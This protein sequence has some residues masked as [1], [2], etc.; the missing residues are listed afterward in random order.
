MPQV[1]VNIGGR[2]Y[3]LACNAGEEPHLEG[4]AKTVD[5]KISEMR[6]SFREIDDQRIVVM[7]ALALADELFEARRKAEAG[8]AAADEL[9]RE[10]AARVGA[11]ARI[12]ALEA[13]IVDSATR[14]EALTE[15]LN[16]PIE[17]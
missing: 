8:A 10:T 7:A 6:G 16:A 3:R 1:S 2:P 11:E 4:L 15:S 14:V 9:S 5:D 12:K 17:D 13:A